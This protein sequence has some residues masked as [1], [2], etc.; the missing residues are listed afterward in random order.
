MRFADKVAFKVESVNVHVREPALAAGR[1]MEQAEEDEG[2]TYVG[3]D[4]R[5]MLEASS[6]DY[7]VNEKLYVVRA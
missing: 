1:T 2:T 6:G 5:R 7:C 3:K 4:M